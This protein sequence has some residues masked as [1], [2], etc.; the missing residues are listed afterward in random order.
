[1]VCTYGC[2]F[3]GERHCAHLLSEQ[4]A[5][6]ESGRF[7]VGLH[8]KMVLS[9]I[10]SDAEFPLL[11]LSDGIALQCGELPEFAGVCLGSSF[12]PNHDVALDVIGGVWRKFVE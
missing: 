7:S 6:F 1:M 2:L 8:D 11:R 9:R 10:G 12:G 4:I 3:T 5:D